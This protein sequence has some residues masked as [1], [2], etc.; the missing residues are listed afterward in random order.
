M[1]RFADRD[2]QAFLDADDSIEENDGGN[3]P[4]VF[5][6][7][8]KDSQRFGRPLSAMSASTAAD[9]GGAGMMVGGIQVRMPGQSRPNSASSSRLGSRPTTA[10]KERSDGR[11]QSPVPPGLRGRPDSFQKG[12]ESM[13]G[14]VDSLRPRSKSPAPEESS[15]NLGLGPVDMLK[16]RAPS[17]KPRSGGLLGLGPTDSL[18]GA[19]ARTAGGTISPLRAAKIPSPHKDLWPLALRRLPGGS[20]AQRAGG[21]LMAP[22]QA[23]SRPTSAV[24]GRREAHEAPTQLAERASVEDSFSPGKEK[25]EKK[26]K[27]EKKEKKHKKDTKDKKDKKE[28]KRAKD[29]ASE[30]SD[31]DG[32]SSPFKAHAKLLEDRGLP[33]GAERQP[34]PP[35]APRPAAV[36]L[37]SSPRP[38]AVAPPSTQSKA[39]G[40]EGQPRALRFLLNFDPLKLTVIWDDAGER[41]RKVLKVDP[42]EI[43]EERDQQK[44]A[45][46][47]VKKWPFLQEQQTNQVERLLRRLV[48]RRFPVYRVVAGNGAATADSPEATEKGARL[49]P[50][51]M[52]LAIERTRCASGWWLRLAN[53]CRWLRE[54]T[55]KSCSP[56][57]A[58]AEEWLHSTRKRTMTRLLELNARLVCSQ[59]AT[60]TAPTESREN[61]ISK[62]IFQEDRLRRQPVRSMRAWTRSTAEEDLI[63]GA[64][65]VRDALTTRG[66]GLNLLLYIGSPHAIRWPM[67]PPYA[68]PAMARSLAFHRC[69]QEG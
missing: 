52:F 5:K 59:L 17:E 44:L 8:K 33:Q 41:K 22:A 60:R 58:E 16:G 56:S 36:P 51:T 40:K 57:L 38:D 31:S 32:S 24:R 2:F 69:L 30:A 37:P 14:P 64:V 29:E 39:G 6:D 66:F 63:T 12:S 25:K 10:Q 46:K 47:L 54:E 11:S 55:V 9:E 50:G 34:A 3:S 53:G 19:G 61:W 7:T 26:Q 62:R 45:R 35:P 23:R 48:S 67:V 4:T 1:S 42:D 15:K 49:P 28:K 20:D 68:G 21:P 13:L 27:K 65:T 18:R 43:S